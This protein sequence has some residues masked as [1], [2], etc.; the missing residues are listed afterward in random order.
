MFITLPQVFNAMGPIGGVVGTLFFLLVFFAAITSSI[1]LMETIVSMVRDKFHWRRIPTTIA[2]T[3]GIIALGSLSVFG[4]GP[5]A[6]FK[7]LGMQML[8]FFDFISNSVLMPI[9]AFLT[10]ILV[11]HVVG[12][13]VIAD[14]VGLSAKFT[15]EKLHRVMIKWVAPILLVVILIAQVLSAF[16]VITI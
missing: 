16:G 2:V 5:L 10:C 14:E 12:T 9:V 15:G 4:Y 8:D 3:I 13:K 6:N 11:G 7:I 1:S